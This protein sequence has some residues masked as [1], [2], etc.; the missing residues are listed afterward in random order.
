MT[1]LEYRSP[2]ADDIVDVAARM[3]TDDVLEVAAS[4]GYT[5]VAAL[6]ESVRNSSVSFVAVLNGRPEA[7][8]GFIYDGG[9][10]AAVWFLAT[11]EATKDVRLFYRE[12][13][14]IANEWAKHFPKMHNKVSADATATRRWL[15]R[16]GFKEGRVTND[17]PVPFIYF[18]RLGV[19]LD[20]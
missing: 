10:A 16:I 1:N 5:P 18:S 3:R 19:G 17:G 7:I 9:E 13:K 6:I 4:G 15:K 11:D 12:S 8:F 14:R 20:V 2:T